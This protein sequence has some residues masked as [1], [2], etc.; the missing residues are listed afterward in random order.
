MLFFDFYSLDYVADVSDFEV[1]FQFESLALLIVAINVF[2]TLN[3]SFCVSYFRHVP[4]LLFV[5]LAGALLFSLV[6][7]RLN[8]LKLAVH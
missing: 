3:H 6:L 5:V 2:H 7:C 4:L 1:D 8:A